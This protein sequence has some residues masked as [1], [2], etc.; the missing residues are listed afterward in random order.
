MKK[1]LMILTAILLVVPNLVFSDVI[2]LKLN[3]FIPRALGDPWETEFENMSFKKSDFQ[4][5]NFAVAYDYFITNEISLT[6]GI[7]GY[8]KSKSG[9]YN[10]YVGDSV[11][12]DYSDYY[13]FDYGEGDPISHVYSVSITPIQA[14]LKLAPLGRKGKFIPYLG[15]GAGVYIWSIQ[16]SGNLIDFDNPELFYDTVLQTDVIGYPVFADDLQARNKFRIGFHA[17]AGVM[18]PIANRISF[19]GEVKY[20]FLE[21]P[22]TELQGF[23]Y[24]VVGYEFF[25]LTGWSISL[26]LNYWF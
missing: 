18:I 7:S 12:G 2:T 4:T 6:L 3:Y 17:M 21:A 14:S 22:F 26:G 15:G 25:D 9:I 10:D 8:T 20:N 16:I 11:L 23:N 24:V 1:Y 19:E 5:T 13:A